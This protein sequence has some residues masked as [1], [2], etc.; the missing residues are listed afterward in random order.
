V[1][2]EPVRER[3]EHEEKYS[4][5]E[6]EESRQHACC[7]PDLSGILADKILMS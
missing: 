2:L 3:T 7:I 5:P 1:N 6:Q 4:Q